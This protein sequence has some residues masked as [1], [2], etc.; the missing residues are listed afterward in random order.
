[1]PFHISTFALNFYSTG[2]L[3]APNKGASSDSFYFTVNPNDQDVEEGQPLRLR[4]AVTPSKDIYYSWLHNGTRINMERE[5]G[6][7]Y[8]EVDSNLQILH[9]DRELDQ[10][11]YQCQALNRSSTFTTASQEARINIYCK[12]VYRSF[13]KYTVI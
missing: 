11:L 13:P 6:R 8:L 2:S 1:M 3:V 12:S 10:G 4:C 5:N 9:A 7:R